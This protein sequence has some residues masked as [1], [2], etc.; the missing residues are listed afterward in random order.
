MKA[1]W[2]RPV[3]MCLPRSRG[4][5]I[6]RGAWHHIFCFCSYLQSS[7]WLHW[8]SLSIHS[9]T[10]KL[11]LTVNKTVVAK[12]AA[13]LSSWFFIYAILFSK[14]IITEENDRGQRESL[15]WKTRNRGKAER[16]G[17]GRSWSLQIEAFFLCFFVGLQNTQAATTP[18][19]KW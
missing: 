16:R 7:L 19:D 3:H 8:S 4:C 1:F 5:S 11:C 15:L 6:F 17:E 14:N 13:F 10:S 12:M 2:T 18:K 9:E